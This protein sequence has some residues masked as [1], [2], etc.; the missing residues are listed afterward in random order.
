VEVIEAF[1]KAE[2]FDELHAAQAAEQPRSVVLESASGVRQQ[3]KPDTDWGD[4]IVK[5]AERLKPQI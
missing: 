1:Y 4:R 3:A 2:K 5:A